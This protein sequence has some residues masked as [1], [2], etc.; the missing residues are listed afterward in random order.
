M[1]THQK[2]RI[3]GEL[4]K[5]FGSQWKAAQRIGLR[6]SRLSLILNGRVEPNGR[7][8]RLLERTLGVEVSSQLST[9]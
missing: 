8:R 6:E 5:K 7:E 3:R 9:R 2:N 1:Q 4:I